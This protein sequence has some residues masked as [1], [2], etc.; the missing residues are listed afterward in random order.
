MG[1]AT[2]DDVDVVV[3]GIAVAH[4]GPERVTVAHTLDVGL[5]DRPPLL[6]SDLVARV[7]RQAGVE[8]RLAYGLIGRPGI[9]KLP[10]QAPG[11]VAGHVAGD[12]LRFL[13]GPRG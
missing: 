10:G 9:G 6:R 7:G 5:G 4:S 1:D 3:V 8:D 11:V 13:D 2:G 12:E